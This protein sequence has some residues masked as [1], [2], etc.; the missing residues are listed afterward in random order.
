[1]I[2][3]LVLGPESLVLGSLT[4]AESS[5]GEGQGIR[6][7]PRMQ[8]LGP[9]P[10]NHGPRTTDHGRSRFTTLARDP[11]S[12]ARLGRL[13]TS[14]GSLETPAF[15]PVGTQGTVKGITPDQL[16]AT[17]TR[18]ILANTFHLAL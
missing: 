8:G 10:D 9:A 13:E 7:E 14:H 5:G 17:G 6:R 3:R 11:G 15:M 2:D 1:M 18:M 4:R 16:R 12:A